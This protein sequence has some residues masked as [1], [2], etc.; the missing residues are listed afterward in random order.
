[1]AS[2]NVTVTI[3]D[4]NVNAV[5]AALQAQIPIQGGENTAQYVRRVVQIVLKQKVKQALAA[6]A[7]QT[8]AQ[9]AAAAVAEP[10]IT[11]S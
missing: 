7:A 8:A 5:I 11:T 2:I 10:P 9:A 6:Q 4:A 1:M 3:P